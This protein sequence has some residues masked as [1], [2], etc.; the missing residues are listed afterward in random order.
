MLFGFLTIQAFCL[1][2]II[3]LRKTQSEYQMNRILVVGA[4]GTGGT[5]LVRELKEA[6]HQVIRASSRKDLAPDQVHLNLV[7]QEGI[8]N[9]FQGVDRAFFLS[10][11]GH[12]RQD[13]LLMP[14]IDQAK[15]VGLKKVVLMTAMGANAIET[16]PM[17]I[18]ELSLE[19]SGVPFNIIRPNWFMQNFNTFWLKGILEQGRIF[20]PVAKAKGSFIDARDIAAVAA[21]LFQSDQLSGQAFDLTGAEAFDHDQVAEILSSFTGR[22]IMYESVTPEAMLNLLNQAGLPSDYA[23]FLILILS[24]FKEGYSERVTDWVEKIT[25]RQPIAFAQYAKDYQTAWR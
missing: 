21:K 16:S 9:A 3:R 18:T 23:D 22:K 8:E 14:L 25:G 5:E 13:L 17:R 19:K 24:Y 6:G 20:L 10:P 2:V 7:N 11:P 15:K 12:T 1:S 4:S